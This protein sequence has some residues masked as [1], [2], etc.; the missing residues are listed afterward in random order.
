MKKAIYVLLLS[1]AA[2]SLAV[3]G[4]MACSWDEVYPVQGDTPYQI[5]VN[6]GGNC[7]IM[8]GWYLEP[9]QGYK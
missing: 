9:I 1:V 4:A 3:S 6:G 2:I 5:E 7:Q 8:L